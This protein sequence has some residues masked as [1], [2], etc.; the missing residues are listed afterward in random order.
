MSTRERFERKLNELRADILAMGSL[1]E[2]ELHMALEALR[3]LDPQIAAAVNEKDV[4]VN[5]TR[6][7]IEEKCFAL[8]V[9]QQPAA[10]DLRAII[11]AMNMI[12]DLERMG[13][14]AKGIAKVVRHL[15]Q[16]PEQERPTGL[17][18]MGQMVSQMIRQAMTAYAH[19]NVDLA[20][21]VATQDDEVDTLYA[22][23]FTDIMLRMAQV[24]ESEQIEASYEILRSARELERFG[25]LATNVAERVIYLVTGSMSEINR[26][27]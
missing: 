20:R 9:T 1:V 14:Q 3:T 25:D 23:V 5:Q 11:T 21:L 15:Q 2:E 4:V 12:V 22:R 13:D 18:A 6:F 27:G 8:I 17:E 16:F 26:D 7:A 24:Q 19:D 10:R